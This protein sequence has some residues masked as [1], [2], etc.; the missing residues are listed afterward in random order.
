M[1]T[2]SPRTKFAIERINARQHAKERPRGE[3][4]DNEREQ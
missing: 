4:E 1:T 2:P 3:G